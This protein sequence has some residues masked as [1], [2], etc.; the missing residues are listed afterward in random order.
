MTVRG[1][2]GTPPSA[3]ALE[4]LPSDAWAVL[5]PHLRAVLNALDDGELPATARALRGQPTGRLAGGRGRREL[6]R[7]LAAGGALW[8]QLVARLAVEDALPPAVQELVTA[9][10]EPGPEPGEG[11]AHAEG[12]ATG[13]RAQGPDATTHERLRARLRAARDDRDAWRRR[14]EGAEARADRLAAQQETIREE[15]DRAVAQ[16]A[17]LERQVAAAAREREQAVDRERRRRD[18]ELAALRD[19]LAAL[20]RAEEERRAERRR[21]EEARQAALEQARTERERAT[22]QDTAPRVVP[23][24][25]SRLPEGVA[26]DTAEGVSLLLNPGR[27]VLVDGYNLTLK[28][29]ADLDLEGQRSWLVTLL[30]TLAAQRRVRPIVVFDGER[31]G[32]ARSSAA[33]DVDV[34][35]T[36]PGV[37]ADDEIVLAVEGTDEPVLVVTDDRELTARVRACRG[38]VVGT[39]PFLWAAT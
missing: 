12:S 30:A 6:C 26:L 15:L 22:P 13:S 8:E 17:E 10:P 7:S 37:T 33:R 27:L 38:D 2:P 24:R 36:P 19:E 3:A 11:G 39:A 4:A 9:T 16:V 5:L 23:G 1:G 20:R 25:P 35:F 34:R 21:Q 14:A 18:A 29:R 31:A 32:G 28:R